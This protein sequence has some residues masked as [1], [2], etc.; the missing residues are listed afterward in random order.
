MACRVTESWRYRIACEVSTRHTFV[1]LAKCDAAFTTENLTKQ[2]RD[3]AI[4]RSALNGTFFTADHMRH[5]DTPG[6]TRCKLCFQEDSLFHRNWECVKL[7]TCREHLKPEQREEIKQMDPATFLQGW[8]PLPDLTFVFRAMLANLPDY[9]DCHVDLP[10]TTQTQDPMHYFTDGSC[11]RPKDRVARI[12]SWGVVC[13]N[14]SDLWS[15]EAVA[16]G[17]LPGRHQTVVRSELTAAAA[18]LHAAAM[19]RH[20]FCIWTDS[21]RV[22]SLL[23]SLFDDPNRVWGARGPNHDLINAVAAEFREAAPYCRGVFKVASHQQIKPNMSPAERWCFSGNDAADKVAE[24]AF[25]SQPKLME[26]WKELTQQLDHRRS[27]RDGMHAMLVA[28]GVECLMNAQKKIQPK[29]PAAKQMLRPL[30]MTAW[31]LPL[32]LPPAAKPYVVPETAAILQWIDGLHDSTKPV[33]RWS[34]WQLYLDAWLNVPNMGPWYHVNSKQWKGGRSQ[35]PESFQ[36]KARWFS[37]YLTKLSKAC[38]VS[39]P[40]QHA[41][42]NGTAIAFWTTT[43]PIRAELSRTEALDSWFGRHMPCASRTSDLRKINM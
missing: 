41:S 10:S 1:G 13:T 40:L 43:L 16:S 4:L 19:R 30:D 11:L 24:Q 31:N 6:D 21:Q 12:C 22:F 39:L 18:A 5:R 34:W 35:P 15:F 20:K 42:P 33:Q 14:K 37:Q 26:C 7:Q 25:Q 2:T 3:R 27:L 38:Q 29:Q 28:I 23:R 32:E 36:R 8:F 17:L 9:F